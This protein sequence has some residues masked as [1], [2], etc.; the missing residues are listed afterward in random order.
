[1]S[2]RLLTIWLPAFTDKEEC[3]E[4]T[5]DHR[6]N[7]AGEDRDPLHS[8]HPHSSTPFGSYSLARRPSIL[9]AQLTVS[10]GSAYGIGDKASYRTFQSFGKPGAW[11]VFPSQPAAIIATAES[12]APF[13]GIYIG[14]CSGRRTV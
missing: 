10:P 13:A 8:S 7:E 4:R 5:G 1:M 14:V 11:P 2:N 12:Q 9:V 3:D 6:E